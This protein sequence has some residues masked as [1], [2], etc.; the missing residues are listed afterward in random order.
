MGVNLLW[1]KEFI[2]I[3]FFE[4]QVGDFLRA[5]F[6]KFLLL[7]WGQSGWKFDCLFPGLDIA[8]KKSLGAA[9][10]DTCGGSELDFFLI[11][12]LVSRLPTSCFKQWF[13]S[14]FTF[15]RGEDPTEVKKFCI[16]WFVSFIFIIASFD[17]NESLLISGVTLCQLN[18]FVSLRAESS[19]FFFNASV[20]HS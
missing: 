8:G 10:T 1:K 13:I 2:V 7:L 14:F 4:W 16:D 15:F 3:C 20:M 19:N 11:F 12:W 17:R 18:P 9:A 5:F 6:S